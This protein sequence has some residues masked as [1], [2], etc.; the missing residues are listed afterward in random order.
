MKMT[1]SKIL[2]RVNDIQERNLNQITNQHRKR[3]IE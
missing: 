2:K 1:K 3:K